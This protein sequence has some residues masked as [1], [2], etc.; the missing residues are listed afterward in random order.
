MRSPPAALALLAMLSACS[1]GHR[2]PQPAP[3]NVENLW[4]DC[5]G[6]VEGRSVVGDTTYEIPR[7]D[8]ATSLRFAKADAPVSERDSSGDRKYCTGEVGETC[9]RVSQDNQL[10]VDNTALRLNDA[11]NAVERVHVTLNLDTRSLSLG[12]HVT[13]EKLDL[14]VEGKPPP[15]PVKTSSETDA[16][17]A[18]KRHVGR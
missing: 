8:Y 9:R 11:Q 7:T 5:V 14:R 15:D 13:V 1:G 3:I 18:C 2:E 16:V 4:L 10:Q 17:L 12:K 6:Y